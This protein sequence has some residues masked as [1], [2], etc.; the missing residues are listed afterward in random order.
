RELRCH[1]CGH[2]EPIPSA[3]PSCGTIGLKPM[4]FGTEKLEEELALIFPSAKVKRMDQDTTRNKNSFKELIDALEKQ[5]ID[6]L[7]GTQMVSKGF[8]FEH[9]SLVGVLD[10]DRALHYPDFR[11]TER[12]FQLLTQV[13]GRAG[14]RKD[15]GKVI[16]QTNQPQHPIFRKIIEN[17]YSNYF[18]SEISEREQFNYPPFSR[19][20]K[21]EI[22]H[23]DKQICHKGS[24]ELAHALI[25]R[26]GSKRMLGPEAPLM[27][28]LRD[29]YL[30]EVWIKLERDKIDIPKSKMLIREEI[31]K[32]ISLKEYRQLYIQVNVDPM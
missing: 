29:Y 9:V 19:I 11:S 8:D 15:Q 28:K 16:I 26:L 7:V 6:I 32:I 23:K 4:G 10:V 20:I 13:S 14:R 27:E 5:E 24:S 30:Q 31:N 12:V 25:Q 21:L 1:Y 17:D 22:K 18:G 3:C 2:H